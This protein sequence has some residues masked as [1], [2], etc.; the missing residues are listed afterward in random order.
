ML[1]RACFALPG[2]I[3]AQRLKGVFNI[4]MATCVRCGGSLSV[5]AWF[6]GQNVIDRILTH[7]REKKQGSSTLPQL[8]PPSRAPPSHCVFWQEANPQPQR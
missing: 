7:R 1:I 3:W 6:E 8:V 2:T 5:I 4:D